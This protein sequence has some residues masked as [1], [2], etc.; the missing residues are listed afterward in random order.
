MSC[1]KITSYVYNGRDTAGC[2]CGFPSPE[3]IG[4]FVKKCENSRC[5]FCTQKSASGVQKK[6]S[7]SVKKYKNYTKTNK[8]HKTKHK[9]SRRNLL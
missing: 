9:T 5:S 7:P 1:K 3:E 2:F 8:K 4:C 6:L